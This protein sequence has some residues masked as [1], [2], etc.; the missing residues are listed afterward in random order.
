MA[1]LLIL[2][3]EQWVW[4]NTMMRSLVHPNSMW[5]MIMLSDLLLVQQNARYSYTVSSQPR[6]LRVVIHQHGKMYVQNM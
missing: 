3:A 2:C 1:Q 4:P 5:L 6:I